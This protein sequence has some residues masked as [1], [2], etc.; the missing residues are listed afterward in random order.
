MIEFFLHEYDLAPQVSDA[1]KQAS[2]L[3]S[4]SE[5]IAN[6]MVMELFAA[7]SGFFS[8]EECFAALEHCNQDIEEAAAYL[9]DQGEQERGKK[10]LPKKQVVLLA[11]SEL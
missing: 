6:P 10:P 11:E 2:E 7:F 9:T 8:H 1:P 4:A 5:L 3:P